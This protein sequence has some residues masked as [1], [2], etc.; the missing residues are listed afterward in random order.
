MLVDN[1]PTQKKDTKLKLTDEHWSFFV[2]QRLSSQPR[3][4]EVRISKHTLDY[5]HQV[6]D[7]RPTNFKRSANVHAHDSISS[8]IDNS[9]APTCFIDNF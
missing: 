8:G 3:V 2:S 5:E 4:K 9:T 7:S 1:R 6:K